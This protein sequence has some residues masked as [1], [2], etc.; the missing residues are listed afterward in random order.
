MTAV[1]KTKQK[2]RPARQY[3]DNVRADLCEHVA[4]GKSA[5]SYLRDKQIS[6]SVLHRWTVEI[7]HFQELLTRARECGYDALADECL[8]IAEECGADRAK[9]EH[10][11]LRIET[12][13]KL[14]ACWD[15][16][17]YGQRNTQDNAISVT[18]NVVDP[19]AHLVT[20]GA[21]DHAPQARLI[22]QDDQ[23]EHTRVAQVSDQ[24]SEQ[25]DSLH[26][27]G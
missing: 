13:L 4:N 6:R 16:K 5:L 11:K 24:A 12:R 22:P 27:T 1:A 21:I 19:T 14:L 23:R 17:R 3:G 25:A 8:Q 15:P 20:V 26:R 7:P 10:A 2:R 18:V 9:I